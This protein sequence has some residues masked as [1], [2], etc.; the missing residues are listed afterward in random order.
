MN[1]FLRG[2]SSYAFSSTPSTSVAELK[3]F[4]HEREGLPVTEQVITYGIQ[5]LEDH[6]TLADYAIEA[7]ST[8]N[9]FVRLHGGWLTK[10]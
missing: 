5:V 2:K 6:A 3:H 1:I 10:Q 4:L 9:A 8:L 7:D